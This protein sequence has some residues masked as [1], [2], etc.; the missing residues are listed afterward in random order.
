MVTAKTKINGNF[1]LLDT[2]KQKCFNSV[3]FEFSSLEIEYFSPKL[4]WSS[5]NRSKLDIVYEGCL[6]NILS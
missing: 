3:L 1:V 5:I 6:I 2:R 4:D